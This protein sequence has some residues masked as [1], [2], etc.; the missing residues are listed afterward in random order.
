MKWKTQGDQGHWPRRL[1]SWA[2]CEPDP[3]SPRPSWTGGL[4]ERTGPSLYGGSHR[5]EQECFSQKHPL[6]H[7][8]EFPCSSSSLLSTR[9]LSGDYGHLIL[10]GAETIDTTRG[11]VPRTGSVH[12]SSLRELRL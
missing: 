12:T 2:A 3:D 9:H 7:F 1:A 5:I 8:G 4:C 6:G 11:R 10:E